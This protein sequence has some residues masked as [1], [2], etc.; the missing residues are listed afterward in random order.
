[1]GGQAGRIGWGSTLAA[2]QDA[3]PGLD[4]NADG[5]RGAGDGRIDQAK[6]VVLSLWGDDGRVHIEALAK[7]R[8]A[9]GQLIFDSIGDSKLTAAWSEFRVWQDAE[10]GWRH[11]RA[12]VKR[13]R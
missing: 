12:R 2:A 11:R 5:T 10:S 8:D 7:A 13:A 9:N 4:L 1:M 6:E 3:L